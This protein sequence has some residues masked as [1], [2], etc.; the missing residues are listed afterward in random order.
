MRFLVLGNPENRRV[1]FFR[2][3]C[4]Q[5]G[6][7]EPKIISW[8]SY[9]KETSAF[10]EA[11]SQCDAFRIES[12][13]ENFDVEQAIVTKGGGPPLSEDHGRLRFLPEW[14][15]GW[16]ETLNEL[17]VTIGSHIRVMN[18]PLDIRRMFHKWESQEELA[19]AGVPISPQIGKP[20]GFDELLAL[21]SQEGV[22]RVFVKPLH[23]SSAS[24]V[25][26]F[27]YSHRRMQAVTSVDLVQGK[28][29]KLYN[30][31][32]LRT[33]S[34]EESC[35]LLFDELCSQKV[36][37]ERWFPKASMNGRS[38]DLR[39]LVVGG[40]ACH[41]VVRTS[42]SPITN[43]HLGNRRGIWAEVQQRLGKEKTTTL[44]NY[45]QKAAGAYPDSL[46]IAVDLMVGVSWSDF[47]VAEVNAFGDLLPNV[48]FD[49]CSTYQLEIREAL[50]WK[51]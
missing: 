17:Q 1:A 23:S 18:P 14:Y 15:R 33:Y 19:A 26:A 12:P 37:V 38:F 28:E 24:G 44:L 32:R 21:M 48:L 47:V 34:N 51:R 31:L 4:R 49:E 42:K 2:E 9:F 29:A 10:L 46:Y 45:A 7:A 43:L 41:V 40:R 16:S 27:Q 13:G 6:L 20:R 25:V 8:E 5:E 30:S 35:R 22:R 36:L 50:S 11:L 3:A 39:I